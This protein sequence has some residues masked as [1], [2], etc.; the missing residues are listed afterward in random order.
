VRA[1]PGAGAIDGSSE[2]LDGLTGRPSHLQRTGAREGRHGQG[3][4]DSS[5]EVCR[6][7]ASGT[8][9]AVLRTAHL[10]LRPAEEVE[11]GLGATGVG[12]TKL[13]K[14]GDALLEVIEEH[15]GRQGR[16]TR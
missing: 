8:D 11:C 3:H 16:G 14:Y 12:P 15:L 6:A 4:H 5:P 10:G 9:S 13:D 1:P 2:P 7:A